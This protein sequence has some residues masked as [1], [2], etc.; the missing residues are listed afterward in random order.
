MIFTPRSECCLKKI[1]LED[2]FASTKDIKSKLESSDIHTSERT[3]RRRL[4]DLQFNT[5]RPARKPKLTAAMRVKRLNWARDL[6]DKN[7]DFWKSV[8]NCTNVLF[9][10]F[11]FLQNTDQ[12]Q[13]TCLQTVFSTL[14]H[15]KL[16]SSCVFLSDERFA[17]VTRAHLKSQQRNL[18]LCEIALAK[19]I[20]RNV[21]YRL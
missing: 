7:L 8:S 15:E 2:Q 16:D 12:M 20:I 21:L 19:N 3:V 6:K 9:F 4:S 17:S 5:Y 14:K 13:Y 10:V 18:N 11:S 1:C